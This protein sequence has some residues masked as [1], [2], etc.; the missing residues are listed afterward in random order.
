MRKN[1]FSLSCQA[2]N[3]FNL[4]TCYRYIKSHYEL[5]LDKGPNYDFLGHPINAYHFVRHVASGWKHVQDH[6]IG[7]ATLRDNLNS[8]KD[9]EQEKLP[10]DYDIKGGAFGLVRLKSLYNF[11][12]EP[13]V[14]EGV[15]STTLDNGQVVLS[16]PSVLKLNCKIFWTFSISEGGFFFSPFFSSF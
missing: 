9:R 2:L 15:I 8:L 5:Q 12:L 6:V 14:E 7:N 4:L 10:D 3:N 13:F 11:K 1:C 16:K